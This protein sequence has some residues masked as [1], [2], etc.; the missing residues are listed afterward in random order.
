[1]VTVGPQGRFV[2]PVRV[3]RALKIAPGDR[4]SLAVEGD[5]LSLEPAAS[6]AARARG[7]LRHLRTDASVVD[8]LIAER[9]E[10]ASREVE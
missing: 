7:M 3:R 5:R 9:R 6:A 4:L 10:E 8:E 2:I 1:M